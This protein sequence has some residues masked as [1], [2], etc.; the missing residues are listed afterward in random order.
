MMN[1]TAERETLFPRRTHAARYFIWLALLSA[2]TVRPETAWGTLPLITDD[3]GTQGRGKF[4]IEAAGEYDRDREKSEGV[5]VEETDYFL[6]STLTYGIAGP[7]DL[8]VTALYQWVNVKN[9]GATVADA[10]GISDTAVGV[11]WRFFE[12]SGLSL[13]VKPLVLIPTGDREKGLGTGKAAYSVFFIVSEDAD[14]WDIHMN[15]GYIRN[16]NALGA[17]KDIWHASMAAAY[18]VVKHLKICLDVGMETNRDKTS[19]VEPSYL[20][21]GFIYAINEDFELALGAKA[22]LNRSETEYSVIPGVTYRF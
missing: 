10:N 19:E 13:A 3:A 16:E 5:S 15:L 1:R 14:P 7:A 4:Q 12:S 21:G 8:F 2:L 20:L 6:G 17:R 11:K 18:E 22:A 9:D